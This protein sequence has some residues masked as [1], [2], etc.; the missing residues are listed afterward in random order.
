[1][2]PF[3]CR[4]R[5]RLHGAS[6]PRTSGSGLGMSQPLKSSLVTSGPLR[7][8]AASCPPLHAFPLLVAKK[9]LAWLIGFTK[10]ATRG[11]SEEYDF[12]SRPAN[13]WH[14]PI[15]WMVRIQ[16]WKTIASWRRISRP[17]L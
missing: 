3:H 15:H 13:W 12:L 6:D 8:P 16:R 7:N 5:F 1:V 14:R 11:V 4:P 9:K 2:V 10:F 17:Q